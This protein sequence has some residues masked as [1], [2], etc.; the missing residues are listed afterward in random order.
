MKA[1]ELYFSSLRPVFQGDALVE[2]IFREQYPIKIKIKIK[3][4]C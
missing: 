1:L 4:Y 2:E 3:S